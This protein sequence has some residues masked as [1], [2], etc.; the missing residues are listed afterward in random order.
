M[1]EEFLE[2]IKGLT[3]QGHT[4]TMTWMADPS[5]DLNGAS[6]VRVVYR[7]AFKFGGTVGRGFPVFSDTFSTEMLK[8]VIASAKAS[9]EDNEKMATAT[10]GK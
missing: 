2:L 3:A 10:G 6:G 5:N 1:N 7:L 4:F 9:V 8:T